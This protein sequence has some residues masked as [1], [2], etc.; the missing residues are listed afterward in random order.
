[1]LPRKGKTPTDVVRELSDEKTRKMQ[2][3]ESVTISLPRFELEWSRELK[4]DLSAMKAPLLFSPQAELS[5]MGEPTAGISSV[6]HMCKMRVDEEG[7][8]AVAVTDMNVAANAAAASEDPKVIKFDHPF[9]VAVVEEMSG[10]R[11][12]EVVVNNPSKQ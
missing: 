10:A 3:S 7:T 9:V 6:L 1:M 12:F 4:N 2:G 5:G 8:V 11:L